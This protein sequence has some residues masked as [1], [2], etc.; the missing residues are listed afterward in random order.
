M[1]INQKLKATES[2]VTLGNASEVIAK[3]IVA[4]AGNDIS[5]RLGASTITL[6]S[7]R[8]LALARIQRKLTPG[9]KQNVSLAIGK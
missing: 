9:Y 3:T 8:G 7:I 4:I 2:V 5:N 1:E 6:N